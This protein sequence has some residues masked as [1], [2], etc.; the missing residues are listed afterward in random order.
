M[1]LDFS[2]LY[3][4]ALL[5]VDLQLNFFLIQTNDGLLLDR[6]TS[7][8]G[9]DNTDGEEFGNRMNC[10]CIDSASVDIKFK[11]ESFQFIYIIIH[12]TNSLF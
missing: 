12:T 9:D 7:L 5:S 1:L 4:T 6:P 3:R 8:F 11:I 10:K 2:L